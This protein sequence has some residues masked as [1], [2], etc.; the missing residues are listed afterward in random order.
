MTS[1]IFEDQSPESSVRTVLAADFDQCVWGVDAREVWRALSEAGPVVTPK[2]GMV[3]VTTTPAVQQVL[4]DPGTFSSNPA[5]MFFGSDTGAIPLQVD[6]PEHS[7][8]RKM[9]DPLFAPRRMAEREPELTVLANDLIDGFIARGHCDFSTEFAV[10]FPSAVFLRLMGLPLDRLDEFL[11][12]KEGMIRPQADTEAERQALQAKTGAWIF[13]YFTTALETHSGDEDA[14]VLGTFLALERGGRLTR[15][16]TLNICLLMLAAGLDTVTDTLECAFAFLSQSPDHQRQLTDHPELVASAV[17]ELLRFDTPV[18]SV[19]RITTGPTQVGGCPVG[20]GERI[21][22][23]LAVPNNDP[24]LHPDPDVVDFRRPVN[25]HIAFG[26]GVHRCVGSHLARIE[27][28]VALAEWHRRIP[29]YRL[30]PGSVVAFRSGLREI[31]H[32]PLEF[33]PGATERLALCTASAFATDCPRPTT[34]RGPI[35]WWRSG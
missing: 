5:A 9:L 15:D 34:C 13:E 14:D 11:V 25:K 31:D 21:R 7:R 29:S 22:V 28:R 2:P 16:E 1:L 18:P 33:T 17:E 10:P 23:L 3:V 20:E 6:P 27:L 24:D 19:A 35:P 8:Y 4:Q 32:L 12:A 26:A 30:Q